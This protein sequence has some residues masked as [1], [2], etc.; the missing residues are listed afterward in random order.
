MLSLGAE[1]KSQQ[2]WAFNDRNESLEGESSGEMRHF[3]G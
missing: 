2:F 1:I 3:Q